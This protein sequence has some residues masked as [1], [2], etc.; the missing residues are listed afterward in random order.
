MTVPFIIYALPRSRTAWLSAFLTYKDW[1]CYHDA[2]GF[3]RSMD[4]VKAFFNSGNVG[5]VETAASYGRCLLKWLIPDL[6]EV[7]ILRPVEECI[8]SIMN[9][10]LRGQAS[11]DRKKITK[12]M[13]RGRKTLDKISKD[14]N[15]LVINYADLDKEETCKSIFEFCLPY[16]FDKNWW[17]EMRHKNIQI[18]ML[19]L[20]QY[21]WKNKDT[22]DDFKNLCKRELFRL[23]RRGEIP[24]RR[25]A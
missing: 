9:L 3:M 15:V 12:L 7:V 17:Q 14:P 23:G 20:L 8:E 4:D 1:E 24:L 6:R 13:E 19:S 25:L 18:N 5:C 10:D 21:R 16:K 2:A 22:I 11:F